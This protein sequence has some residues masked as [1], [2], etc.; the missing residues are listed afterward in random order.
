MADTKY[1]ISR[2]KERDSGAQPERNRPDSITQEGKDINTALSHDQ[3]MHGVETSE[4]HQGSGSGD[5][6]SNKPAE[7]QGGY[8]MQDTD[9]RPADR[10]NAEGNAQVGASPLHDSRYSRDEERARGSVSAQPG[11][12]KADIQDERPERPGHDTPEGKAHNGRGN[13]ERGGYG[14]GT[15]NPETPAT[16]KGQQP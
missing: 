3:R 6:Q 5:F 7:D 4:G 13:D 12:E 9:R 10:D 16:T 15:A 11:Q 1:P 8:G 2:D 14:V